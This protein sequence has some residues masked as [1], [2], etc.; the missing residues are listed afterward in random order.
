MVKAERTIQTLEDI[1]RAC[2][3]D[4]KGNLDKHL[5]SVEFAYNNSFI[6][7][8]SWLLIKPCMVRGLCILLDG[9]KWVRLRFLVPNRFIKLWRNFIS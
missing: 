2:I 4:F 5:P 7:P 1:L 6:H 3:I 8:F 9:F